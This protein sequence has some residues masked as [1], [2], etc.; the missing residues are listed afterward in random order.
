VRNAIVLAGLLVVFLLLIT[1]AFR[2]RPL[3]LPT[4]IPSHPAKPTPPVVMDSPAVTPE[5]QVILPPAPVRSESK[6][7]GARM[8]LVKVYVRDVFGITVRAVKF[9]VNDGSGALFLETDDEGLAVTEIRPNGIYEADVFIGQLHSRHPLVKGE[10]E[11][12]VPSHQGR[13]F[14]EVAILPAEWEKAAV[15]K[16]GWDHWSYADSTDLEVGR[17]FLFLRPGIYDI[18]DGRDGSACRVE[19]VAG[20][21]TTFYMKRVGAIR[22]EL[23]FPVTPR[24]M[25][26]SVPVMIRGLGHRTT[27]PRGYRIFMVTKNG[28]LSFTEYGLEPGT[29]Q[30]SCM[31]T[32]YRPFQETVEVIEGEIRKVDVILVQSRP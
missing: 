21:R 28:Q 17:R 2:A 15:R 26:E 19:V 30:V 23:T 4:A 32:P 20:Q 14:G 5:P 9:I 27:H 6:P 11:I 25:P 24:E 13:E 12:Q 16:K 10:N 7:S 18:F 8:D 31:D 1:A 3:P 29:Y 22:L